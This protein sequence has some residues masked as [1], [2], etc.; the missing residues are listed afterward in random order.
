MINKD[1]KICISLAIQTGN[2]GTL[3]HNYLYEQMQLNYIYKA[4]STKKL[5]EAIGGIRALNIRGCGVSM[6]YKVECIQYLDEIDDSASSIGAVNTIVNSNGCLKGYNTDYISIKEILNRLMAE[7]KINLNSS[8]GIRG[9]GGM[10][11][12]VLRALF[13]TGFKN[14]TIITRNEVAG[15]DLAELYNYSYQLDNLSVNANVLIN[16]TSIGMANSE[17]SELLSFDIEA[18]NQASVVCD[19]VAIP[20]ETPLIQESRRQKKHIILGDEIAT[21]QALEQFVLYTGTRPTFELAKD[22]NDF[23]RI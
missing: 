21:I 23:A 12:A 13:D 19:V 6:P 9:N 10:A 22:A 17:S 16:A 8:F 3:F 4:F 15:R 14:I 7:K 20:V 18:I 11:K 5:K 2:F 1:T